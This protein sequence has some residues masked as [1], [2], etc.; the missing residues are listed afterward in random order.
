VDGIKTLDEVV[1]DHV[2]EV[3]TRFNGEREQTAKALNFTRRTLTTHLKRYRE[4]GFYIAPSPHWSARADKALK[5]RLDREA[6]ERA[7][8]EAMGTKRAARIQAYYRQNPSHR[9]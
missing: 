6:K 4:Q 2:L 5:E 9:A 8:D 1:R 3:L 7:E